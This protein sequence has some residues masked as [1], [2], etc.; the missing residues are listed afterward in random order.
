[1]YQ[2]GEIIL[3]AFPFTDSAAIKKRPALVLLDTGDGDVLVARVTTQSFPSPYEIALADW[4]TAGLLAS[5]FVKINKLAT[6]ETSLV[7]RK[8][9]KLTDADLALIREKLKLLFENLK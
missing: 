5:S 9:G 2:F 1:M 6:L 7:E 3:L 8:L 4:S